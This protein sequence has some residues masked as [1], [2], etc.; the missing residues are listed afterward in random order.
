MYIVF[1]L[2]C[3]RILV[4]A[5]FQLIKCPVFVCNDEIIR[6]YFVV[7]LRRL[8]LFVLFLLN[9]QI[10]SKKKKVSW[11]ILTKVHV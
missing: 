10:M 11:S 6:C 5:L 1:V 3:R 7:F 2:L 8:F 4:R 9:C